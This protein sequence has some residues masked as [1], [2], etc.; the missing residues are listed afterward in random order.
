MLF[1]ED[2]M[3]TKRVIKL[4]SGILVLLLLAWV[5]VAQGQTLLSMQ[6]AGMTGLTASCGSC[7]F[8]VS[9]SADGKTALVG[10]PGAASS[11]GAVYVFTRTG[12]IWSQQ[13]TLTPSDGGANY[14]FG[15]SVSLGS[16]GYTAVIGSIA[17]T[18]GSNTSQGA[19]YVFTRSGSTWLQQAE[20]TAPDGATQD[21]F[22]GSV[23]VST[24]G[25]TVL[26]GASGNESAYVFT[27]SGTTW[28]LWQ[29][30]AASDGA[31]FDDFGS[32]VSLSGDGKTALIGAP[33]KTIGDNTYQGAAYV[34]VVNGNAWYPL[35]E[36]NASDGAAITGFGGS[37]AL[38]NGGTALIGAGAFWNESPPNSNYG[39]A[40]YLFTGPTVPF[41]PGN[42]SQQAEI[43]PSDS[44]AKDR[45]GAS[46]ALSSDGSKALVGTPKKAVG[47]GG[48]AYLFT[49]SGTSWSQQL[50]LGTSDGTGG[51]LFGNSVSLSGDGSMLLIGAPNETVGSA[52]YAGAAYSASNSD[53]THFSVTAPTTASSGSAF[54]ITVTALDANN[55]TVP[56]Y[57]DSVHFTST[58]AAAI[59]PVDTTLD[60]GA[61][62]LGTILNTEGTQTITA[63]DAANSSVTGS[64]AA[65]MVGA[66]AGSG[67]QLNGGNS[68]AGNQ[69]VN[70][71]VTATS[72]VG[73]GSG[74]TGIV[75]SS[76]SGLTCTGCVGNAQL[77]VNYALGDSQGGNAVNALALGGLAASSFATT[78]PNLFVGDQHIV[79]NLSADHYLQAS[80]ATIEGALSVTGSYG[81]FLT[82]LKAATSAQG[83]NSNP[84]YLAAS[85]FNSSQNAPQS[86]TFVWQAEP[87][88]SSNNTASPSATLNLLAGL[89][90]SE[91]ETGL[92]INANGTINFASSQ[93]FPGTGT[94]T[95]SGVT[96]GTG[97]SGG[98]TSGN[99]TLANTGILSLTAGPGLISTGGQTPALNLDTTFTD[100]RYLQL[101][102]GSLIGGLAAPSFAGNGSG[103]TFLN[104]ANLTPGGTGQINITGNAATA[105]LAAGATTA[106]SATTAGNA[107]DLGGIA[108]ADYARVDVGNSFTG[109]QN[110][111]G[112]LSVT[113]TITG[114]VVIGT[115]G[116]PVKEHVSVLVNPSFPA[117]LPF[118]CA[119]ANFTV[120]AAIDGN[121][122]ALG[123]PNARMNQGGHIVYSAWV[124]AAN[125]VTVQACNIDS[126]NKQKAPGSGSIRLDLW[127]Y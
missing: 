22:G 118:A 45:F 29:K 13:A 125:T 68:F 56:Y 57:T 72:F 115:G 120:T 18:V 110:V 46:V 79:G 32:S 37:V 63:S 93:T 69:T 62:T 51:D 88:A 1:E 40:A 43:V 20:L 73:N 30:L 39:G 50:E 108:A 94:G 98:G 10:A 47:E 59:L 86:P 5:A 4:W 119:T 61:A 116:T 36:L 33:Y 26:V 113:G 74:L 76:A 41:G 92:Y 35:A 58:D 82:R 89:D 8:A 75:A 7:G 111:N 14:L 103:L 3:Q 48:A 55:Y 53:V 54:N 124:S 107:A 21:Y 77:G 90:P 112:N 117:L 34:F 71:T 27:R 9:V 15:S 101:T 80:G 97:L 95:I 16:D 42:W 104:A 99:V 81:L 64:S 66:G 126:L 123:V 106:A 102:G 6:Q 28:S 38:I 17:K 31:A 83:A 96:A 11:A 100:A 52:T 23:S 12:T 70:G 2:V 84:L 60:N 127:M 25:N 78:G 105:T 67:A 109:N 121:T 19:A 65:I 85:V 114:T 87:V 91:T 122:I 24:D 44:V 49:I